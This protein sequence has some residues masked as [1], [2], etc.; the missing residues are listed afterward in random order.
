VHESLNSAD[1]YEQGDRKERDAARGGREYFRALKTERPSTLGR[2]PRQTNGPRAQRQ[3][4]DIGQ[5][6][7]RVSQERQGVAHYRGDDFADQKEADH[8]EDDEDVA[9]IAGR[10]QG[11]GVISVV[12]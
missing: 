10:R 1:R 12:V 3:R 8:S 9:H 7:P 2:S 4:G 11:V 5:H 6:V